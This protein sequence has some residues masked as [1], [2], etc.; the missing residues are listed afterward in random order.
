MQ[1]KGMTTKEGFAQD[2]YGMSWAEA[3][4]L[5]LEVATELCRRFLERALT[6]K[7]PTC[8]SQRGEEEVQTHEMA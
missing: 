5:P 6:T 3:Q 4:K 8:E 1:E 7:Q 2:C